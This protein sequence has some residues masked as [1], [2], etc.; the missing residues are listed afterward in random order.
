M[1]NPRLF[2]HWGEIVIPHGKHELHQNNKRIILTDDY[3]Y[4]SKSSKFFENNDLKFEIMSREE[5]HEVLME[6]VEEQ[7]KKFKPKQTIVTKTPKGAG[8][9]HY[10]SIYGSRLGY[11]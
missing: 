1:V 3:K 5:C 4:L 10:T 7:K 2:D 6:Y 9:P 8:L 11:G